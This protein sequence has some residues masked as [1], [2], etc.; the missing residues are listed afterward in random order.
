[1]FGKFKNEKKAKIHCLME[2]FSSVSEHLQQSNKTAV[3]Q[4]RA[5][6]EETKKILAIKVKMKLMMKWLIQSEQSNF[7]IIALPLLL[8]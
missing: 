8:A 3:G 6:S 5:T 1:M 2:Q 7:H 4:L